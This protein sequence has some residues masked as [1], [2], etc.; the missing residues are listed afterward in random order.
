M[1][2]PDRLTAN[3]QKTLAARSVPAISKYR[4]SIQNGVLELDALLDMLEIRL[5]L[6][7]KEVI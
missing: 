3:E 1:G 6:I 2:A 4:S 7:E 5:L